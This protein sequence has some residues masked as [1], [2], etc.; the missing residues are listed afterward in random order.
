[1]ARKMRNGR[2][3]RGKRNGNASHASYSVGPIEKSGVYQLGSTSFQQQKIYRFFLRN[4]TSGVSS[5]SSVVTV[6]LALND[7]SGATDWTS[8]AGLFDLYRVRAFH[9]TWI[10]AQAAGGTDT[11]RPIYLAVDYDSSSIGATTADQMLQR[12][13]T[14][15]YNINQPFKHTIRMP[16]MTEANVPA[17]WCD[18]AT[19]LAQGV[20]QILSTGLAT[21]AAYGSYI[22]EFDVEF[23]SRL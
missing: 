21:A 11:V 22:T 23:K 12:G 18:V 2:R 7:P 19:P 9:F 5:S 14:R 17:G 3:R 15:I 20:M 4:A 10:P 6:T 16:L 13:T 8:L 1:M